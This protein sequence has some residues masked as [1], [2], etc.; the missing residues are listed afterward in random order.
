[1]RDVETFYHFWATILSTYF[2]VFYSCSFLIKEFNIF[3]MLALSKIVSGIIYIQ[4]QI[5]CTL[6]LFW[7]VPRKTG[8][9]FWAPRNN[10]TLVLIHTTTKGGPWLSTCGDDLQNESLNINCR[11]FIHVS[12][13][14]YSLF[15]LSLPSPAFPGPASHL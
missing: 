11:I 1:M 8:A 10:D 7:H 15:S 4:L 13:T 2:K 6:P 3:Y 12:C 5:V 9:K 14:V